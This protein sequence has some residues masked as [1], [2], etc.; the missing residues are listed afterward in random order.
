M[1]QLRAGGEWLPLH[2]LYCGLID[3]VVVLLFV[4]EL[5]FVWEGFFGVGFSFRSSLHSLNSLNL[6]SQTGR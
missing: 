4:L 3:A 6:D 1:S 5:L 2:Q